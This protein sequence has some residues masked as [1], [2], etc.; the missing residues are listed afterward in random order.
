MKNMEYGYL[1]KATDKLNRSYNYM[2][3]GRAKEGYD[4]ILKNLTLDEETIVDPKW[5][6]TRKIEPIIIPVL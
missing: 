6:E 5:F 4:L 1:F 3:V 2:F